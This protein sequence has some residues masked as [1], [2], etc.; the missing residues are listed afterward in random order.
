[1]LWDEGC[2]QLSG[3]GLAPKQQLSYLS[4]A[5]VSLLV[6]WEPIFTPCLPVWDAAASSELTSENVCTCSTRKPSVV[7]HLCPWGKKL[8]ILFRNGNR[9][10]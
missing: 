4:R 3:V 10:S 1:M 8:S 6:K 5:P 2:A 7:K 9:H